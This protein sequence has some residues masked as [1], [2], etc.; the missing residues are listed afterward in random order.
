MAG[1]IFEAALVGSA[2]LGAIIDT[3][4][5][6]GSTY[7]FALALFGLI[8]AWTSCPRGVLFFIIA[9]A[10][11][12]ILDIVYCA[13]YSDSR[14]KA[15][16][17]FVALHM[18]VKAALLW[19]AHLELHRI[20]GSYSLTCPTTPGGSAVAAPTGFLTPPAESKGSFEKYQAGHG[21]E[22][23]AGTSHGMPAGPDG[24]SYHAAPAA[25]PA[26]GMSYQSA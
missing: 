12:L 18:F 20:G 26:A 25:D 1:T 17:V 14:A 6:A 7:N 19:L 16:I 24:A 15:A 23:M 13:V 5:A 11:T 8:V 21:S 3:T 22:A 9:E 2:L 10:I 4:G